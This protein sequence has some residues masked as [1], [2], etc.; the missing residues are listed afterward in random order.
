VW[1]LFDMEKTKKV[2]VWKKVSIFNLS[3]FPS[4]LCARAVFLPEPRP[5]K[6]GTENLTAGGTAILENTPA[7][8]F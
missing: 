8:G 1:N 5:E 7:T 4:D 2:R 6:V 3:L